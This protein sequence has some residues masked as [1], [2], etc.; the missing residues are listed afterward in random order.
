LQRLTAINQS[1]TKS[2]KAYARQISE[3][4]KTIESTK[5]LGTP[6]SSILTSDTFLELDKLEQEHG[7]AENVASLRADCGEP[8]IHWQEGECIKFGE[9]ED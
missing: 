2:N 1:L 8:W 3:L 4:Q 6:S 9:S 7:F 5:L